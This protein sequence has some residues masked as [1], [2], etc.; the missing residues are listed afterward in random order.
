MFRA[1]ELD[2]PALC[3]SAAFK[4]RPGLPAGHICSPVPAVVVVDVVIVVS[5]V[6]KRPIRTSRASV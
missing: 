5:V 1:A 6:S 2:P 3:R 4:T